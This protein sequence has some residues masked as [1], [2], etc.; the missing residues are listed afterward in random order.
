MLWLYYWGNIL[1]L[2]VSS[3]TCNIQV[4]YYI[5][6][7][8]FLCNTCTVLF[9]HFSCYIYFLLMMIFN[10]V[11][12]ACQLHI[13]IIGTGLWYFTMVLNITFFIWNSINKFYL[14]TIVRIRFRF[15]FSKVGNYV[16]NIFALIIGII[17]ENTRSAWIIIMIH[18]FCFSSSHMVRN[19]IERK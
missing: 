8:L 17:L 2:I 6:L 18:Q 4:T 3:C 19:T 5:V 13:F 7:F 9:Y 16:I 12:S 11:A 1:F 14:S 15:L 10:L